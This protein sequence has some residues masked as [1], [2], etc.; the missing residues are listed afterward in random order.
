MAGTKASPLQE[1]FALPG[2]LTATLTPVILRTSYP[3]RPA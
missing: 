1:N 2:L 3:T